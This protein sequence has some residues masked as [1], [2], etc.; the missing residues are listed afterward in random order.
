MSTDQQIAVDASSRDPSVGLRAVRSLRALVE[1]LELLQ[2]DNARS[3]GWSW[4]EIAD[5]LDV[6]R[7][8]V[9]KKHARRRQE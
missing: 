6:S 5:H 8:A 7:Q 1:R 4:Q 3:Q 2:V 9:H